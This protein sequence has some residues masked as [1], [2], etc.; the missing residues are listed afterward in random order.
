ML[1]VCGQ[2]VPDGAVQTGPMRVRVQGD[3]SDVRRGYLI[4]RHPE[5]FY[6]GV[7]EAYRT[8]TPGQVERAYPLLVAV[9]IHQDQGSPF[10]LELSAGPKDAPGAAKQVWISNAFVVLAALVMA[11]GARIPA[12]LLKVLVA[13]CQ[14]DMDYQ[15]KFLAPMWAR[16]G[17]PVDECAD[18]DNK[19]RFLELLQRYGRGGR[20]KVVLVRGIN[21][22]SH[23]AG[24]EGTYDPVEVR[25][26]KAGASGEP[27]ETLNASTPAALLEPFDRAFFAAPP[28]V[29]N[30]GPM[31]QAKMSSA[32]DVQKL[33]ERAE[34]MS[35]SLGAPCDQLK[36]EAQLAMMTV[37]S[38][39]TCDACG[40]KGTTDKPLRAC[41]RCKVTWFCDA[42]CQRRSW[43]SGHK[44][45]CPGLAE[46]Y[47]A[48]K[49]ELKDNK[50][51]L[52]D[53]G[54][55]GA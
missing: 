2:A 34:A 35:A 44:S 40:A 29:P 49:K 13:A 50:T 24:S 27:A 52:K 36:L 8:L 5:G 3:P 7:R 47:A 45:R 19:R 30:S 32:E 4:V 18:M 17:Y 46:G 33:R 22:D 10:L 25:T 15:R 54:R 42:T 28:P 41:S 53:P 51:A 55:T 37:K 31:V 43:T 6:A 20:K 14:G 26:A 21:A 12:P 39:R 11:S 1:R 38:D 48:M 16:K 9:A 23:V